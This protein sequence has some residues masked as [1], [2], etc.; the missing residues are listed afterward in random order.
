MERDFGAGLSVDEVIGMSAWLIVH[1]D[2][3]SGNVFST[4][5][6]AAQIMVDEDM[7]FH[8]LVELW[9]D[10]HSVWMDPK[11]RRPVVIRPTGQLIRSQ[12]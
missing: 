8:F 3:P 7:A 11:T 6:K 9:E 2:L 10:G 12:S 1:S 4:V 5:S